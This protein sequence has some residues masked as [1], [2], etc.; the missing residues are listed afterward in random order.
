MDI[1]QVGPRDTVK[2]IQCHAVN[3]AVGE[4]KV[5]THTVGV[6]CKLWLLLLLLLVL[7]LVIL[8]DGFVNELLL[9]FILNQICVIKSKR[10]N[11]V[12]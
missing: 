3:Q 1:L 2:N 10:H 12:S 9:I 7:L 6:L 5:H 4:T 8:V 11:L